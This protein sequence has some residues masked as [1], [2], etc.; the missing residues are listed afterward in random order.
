MTGHL[1]L[2]RGSGAYEFNQN[3]DY[4]GVGIERLASETRITLPKHRKAWPRK[5]TAAASCRRS[6]ASSII[7]QRFS[8]AIR[9]DSRERGVVANWSLHPGP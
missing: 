3:P 2:G 4:Y 9:V 1:A 5:R 8:R 7:V 6:A